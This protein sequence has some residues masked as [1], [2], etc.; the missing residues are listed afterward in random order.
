MLNFDIF[1]EAAS[2]FAAKTDP[3]F[4]SLTIFVAAFTVFITAVFI[5]L[6]LKFKAVP[7]RPSRHVENMKAEIGWSIAPAI[8]AVGIFA[9]GAYIYFDYMDI[10]DSTYDVQ[11]VGKQWMWKLQHPNGRREV[12][13]L[14]VPVGTP[15]KITMTSQDVLHDFYIPAFRVKQDVLPAR[16]TTLWF[17]ATKTGTFP[18]FC[19]EY[20][21]TE[22]STMVGEVHVLPQTEFQAW[23]GGETGMTP[24]E[25][26]AALFQQMGCVTCHA[27]GESSRGPALEGK[28]GTQE[29]LTDGSSVSVDEEYLRESILNPTAKVVEGYA[30]LMPTFANQLSEEDV[31]NL[32]AYI[33]SL[34][35]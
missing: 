33:K 23:L 3:F 14:T 17:E 19:A 10:P 1:P 21:G 4:W 30:P 34:S 25:S 26:G 16:Y 5:Y 13:Q 18:L 12:N 24:A 8:I 7:G 2:T 32:I 11:V 20:C 22:H 29:R 9:W 31:S 28:F 27:A 15:V 35:E 6:G